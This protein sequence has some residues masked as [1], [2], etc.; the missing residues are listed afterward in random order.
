MISSES[1][2]VASLFIV[3]P[4][5]DDFNDFFFFKDLVD[6]TVLDID[7]S[8]TSARQ[9]AF[10]LFMRGRSLVGIAIEDTEHLDGL[11]FEARRR[12]LFGV[13][14]R[15]SGVNQF[16]SHQEIFLAHLEVGVL[17]PATM[18]SRMPGTDRRYRVS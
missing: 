7:P 1:K 14:L 4:E 10:Q 2:T 12:Q 9:V 11:V 17:S 8:R 3:R 13:L 15:L 18:D 16:P 5:P 6:Q